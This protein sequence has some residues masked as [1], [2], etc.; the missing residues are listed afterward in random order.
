MIIITAPFLIFYGLLL[1]YKWR[2][3]PLLN[4]KLLAITFSESNFSK[5]NL[6]FLSL[7]LNKISNPLI[8][9]IAGS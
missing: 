7:C 9:R 5:G 8:L 3:S 4:N 6:F 2:V 1:V